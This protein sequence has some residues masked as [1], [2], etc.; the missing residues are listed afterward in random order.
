MRRRLPITRTGIRT[1]TQVGIS[2]VESGPNSRSSDHLMGVVSENEVGQGVTLSISNTNPT[3]GA[4][5][6]VG[7]KSMVNGVEDRF[8]PTELQ[9]SRTV[10]TLPGGNFNGRS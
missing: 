5:R 3:S 10:R 6:A 9:E 7:S 8:K 4:F 2:R 1:S